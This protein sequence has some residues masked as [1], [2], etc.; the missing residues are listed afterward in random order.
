MNG[1]RYPDVDFKVSNKFNLSTF[2]KKFVPTIASILLWVLSTKIQKKK[3]KNRRLICFHFIE[4]VAYYKT[5]ID[6]PYEWGL[7]AGVGTHI[8]NI[9]F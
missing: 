8:L 3:T 6:T 2:R 1:L 4:W 7:F 5:V 9:T